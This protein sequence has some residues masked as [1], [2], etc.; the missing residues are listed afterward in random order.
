MIQTVK[1]DQIFLFEEAYN[2]I[3][4]NGKLL[5]YW[6]SRNEYLKTFAYWINEDYKNKQS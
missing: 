2:T 5:N 3:R 1:E 6:K 4:Q